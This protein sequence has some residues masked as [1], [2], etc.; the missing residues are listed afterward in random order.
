MNYKSKVASNLFCVTINLKIQNPCLRLH[1]KLFHK[2]ILY[3]RL[4]INKTYQYQENTILSSTPADFY[5]PLDFLQDTELCNAMYNI[6][7]HKSG[8][9]IQ[10][11]SYP[12]SFTPFNW[13]YKIYCSIN[14]NII[15]L[16]NFWIN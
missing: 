10:N 4:L 16:N 8:Y 13:H 6:C 5:N 2:T 14:F 3:A 9:V 1:T 12:F 7:A 11:Q 15:Y